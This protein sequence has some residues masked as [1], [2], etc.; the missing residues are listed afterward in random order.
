MSD[1]P[2]AQAAPSRQVTPVGMSRTGIYRELADKRVSAIKMGVRTLLLVNSVKF[3]LANLPAAEFR[4][5]KSPLK[6]STA[7]RKKKPEGITLVFSRSLS[8]PGILP[9]P[10]L[11]VPVAIVAALNELLD[12]FI[13]GRQ[14]MLRNLRRRLAAAIRHNAVEKVHGESRALIGMLDLEFTPAASIRQ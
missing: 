7:S 4:S 2:C 11:Q 14:A 13:G 8:G 9:R 3:L 10:R 1:T 6:T 12:G 5:P